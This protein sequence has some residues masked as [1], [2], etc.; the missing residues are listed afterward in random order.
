[1]MQIITQWRQGTNSLRS[2]CEDDVSFAPRL[3]LSIVTCL[4]ELCIA[5]V[6][7]TRLLRLSINIR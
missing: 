1:M 5:A 6:D 4:K 2:V 7:P 3:R